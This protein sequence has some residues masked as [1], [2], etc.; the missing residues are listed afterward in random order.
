M[1]SL[2]LISLLLVAMLLVAAC[3]AAGAPTAVAPEALPDSGLPDLGGREVTVAIE[4]AYLPF[5]YVRLDNGQAE[6]WDYD[7]V[8]EICK[9]LNCKPVFQE[10]AWDNMIASVGQGQFDMAADGITIT[11]ERA[12]VVDFSDGYISVEQRF[13]TRLD[14][15][16]YANIDEVINDPEAVVATQKG[17]T[18]FE[19]AVDRVGEARVVAFDTFGD[20]VQAL[21]NG[22]ADAVIIDDTAGQGYV[23]VNAESI[24]LVEGSLS[25]DQ[26]GFIFPKGSTLVGPFNA[27]LAAMRADGTLAALAD[28]WFS[29][30]FTVTYD[31]IGPGAYGDE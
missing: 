6:G 12:E 9:R 7:A 15:D 3:Q 30:Q 28:K 21:I 18:N 11:E 19:T 23:G 2:R 20:A 5:N 17:T 26:L 10:I 29:D 27:A 16:R 22:D 1:K 31:D 8:G 24:Q 4:N 13:M 25:S 14:D